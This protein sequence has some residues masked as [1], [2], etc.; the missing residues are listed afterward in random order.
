MQVKFPFSVSGSAGQNF[1]VQVKF[2]FSGNGGSRFV[3]T[4]TEYQQD[5][6]IAWFWGDKRGFVHFETFEAHDLCLRVEVFKIK[7]RTSD[8]IAMLYHRA[9]KTDS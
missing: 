2:S 3:E 1:L 6:C 4:D 9:K 8:K 5:D 7:A